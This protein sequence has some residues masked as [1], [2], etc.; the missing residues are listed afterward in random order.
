MTHQGFTL[1]T[2]TVKL[3]SKGLVYAKENP[4]S[5]GEIEMKYMT[6]KEEDILT[7]QNYISQGIVFDKLFQSMIVS[8]INYDDL[9]AGD[10]NAILMAARILGYGKDYP[11]TYPNPENGKNEEFVVDLTRFDHKE[12]DFSIFNNKNEFEYTLP[13]SGNTVTFKLLDGSDDRTIEREIKS[14]KKA[15]ISNEMTL[16]LKQQILSINGNP[17]KKIIREFVDTGLLAADALALRKYIKEISPDINMTFTFV[18]ST[19]YTEEGVSLP[20]GLSFF[21]PQL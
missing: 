13:K 3:P 1:P 9:I 15:N 7:N 5:S 11:I 17:D 4:L 16:R 8:K 20:V 14:L 6:A 10:K 12:V 21:Y 19:G 2:E 18:G